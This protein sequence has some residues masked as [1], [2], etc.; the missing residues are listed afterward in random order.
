M[1]ICHSRVV[2]LIW[3]NYVSNSYAPEYTDLEFESCR[4][5]QL[6]FGTSLKWIVVVPYRFLLECSITDALPGRSRVVREVMLVRVLSQ[7]PPLRT[8]LPCF[9]KYHSSVSANHIPSRS[10]LLQFV[11]QSFDLSLKIKFKQNWSRQVYLDVLTRNNYH[12]WV[13]VS[14]R[15]IVLLISE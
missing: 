4:L 7:D 11:D 6:R 10:W 5:I 3:E 14:Q 8:Y 9:F 15:F 13:S 2:T 1:L 12:W